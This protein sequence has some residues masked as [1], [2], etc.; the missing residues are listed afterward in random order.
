[1]DISTRERGV[2]LFGP[3]RLDPVRR[4]LLRDGVQVVLAPR[5]FDTLLHLVSNHERLVEKGELIAAVWGRRT[6]EEANLSQAIFALRKVLQ[7]G[8]PDPSVIVT[9]P[10]RGY[11]CGVPVV[12]EAAPEA[13]SGTGHIGPPDAGLGAAGVP[14]WWRRPS[15]VI[16]GVLALG[17][18]AACGA[19]WVAR[20]GADRSALVAA[21]PFAPPP[22]SLAV[23]AFTNLSGDPAQE[24]FSDGLSEELIDALSHIG[25]LHVTARTSSFY[26]K[27]RAATVAEIARQ[28]NVGAVLEGSF[29]RA[30]SMLRVSVTLVDA[31]TGFELW[32][33]Q[34]DS[35]A[36]DTIRLQEQIAQ[37]VASSL[38][39]KLLDADRPK[40][41]LGGT[42]NPKAFDAY[43]R[44]LELAYRDP[45]GADRQA[46][47]A[48]SQA[49]ALDQNFANARLHRAYVLKDMVEFGAGPDPAGASR[50]LDDALT[51][52]DAAIHVAPGLGWAHAARA[53]VLMDRSLSLPEI[54]TEFDVARQL[55]PDDPGIEAQYGLYEAYLGH[56]A[57]AIA[58]AAQAVALDPVSAYK[59]MD[60]A[61]IYYLAR[62]YPDAVL[63]LGRA[64][65]FSE[66]GANRGRGLTGFVALMMN[67]AAGAARD[68]ADAG[69]ILQLE[70]L[71]LA[72]HKL[73]RTAES[74]ALFGKLQQLA[75]DRGAY[76]YAEIYAQTAQR[77]DALR[78]LQTAYRLHDAGLVLLKV[79][80]VLDPIR[81]APE[82]KDIEARL[83]FPS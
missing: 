47:A 46:L 66:Q 6:V 29:R 5:L 69:D 20:S 35:D 53:S 49:I 44:G 61:E 75:G 59:H 70:C 78:W 11:R 83:H 43:I 36:G 28:L 72:Y 67:D 54:A 63:S 1:M 16:A 17:L 82:L 56:F 41:N 13:R 14:P 30:G 68:C 58:A 48:F 52:I 81:D 50:M 9:A 24:Y 76:N 27:G 31:R 12:F 62:R 79:D 8:G 60:Q 7:A 10:G 32:S 74:A 4:T 26:F 42:T 39:V 34:Y 15:I 33:G 21:V 18:A 64:D 38:Q 37:A 25:A 2:F 40:L 51:D 77:A 19:L 23:L 65:Y 22:H 55:A 45:D 71:V 3:F 80:P 73:G 57:Q